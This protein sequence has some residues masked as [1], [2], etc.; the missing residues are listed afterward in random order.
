MRLPRLVFWQPSLAIVLR[1]YRVPMQIM[2]TE[3]SAQIET[4]EAQVIRADHQAL[5]AFRFR[6]RRFLAWSEQSARHAGLEPQQHQMM[7][8]I[9]GLPTGQVATI[10]VVAERLQIRH[11]TAVEL[12]DRLAIKGLLVRSRT[13]S[14]HREVVISLTPEGKQRLAPLVRQSLNT[15]TETGPQLID[16]LRA[17]MDHASRR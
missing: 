11:H 4:A 12:A 6:L 16:A 1:Y 13:S 14:D 15:L 17:V 5:A 3:S 9:S 8:A 7:L 10:G 2:P